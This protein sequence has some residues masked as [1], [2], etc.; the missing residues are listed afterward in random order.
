MLVKL[1]TLLLVSIAVTRGLIRS[2]ENKE[3]LEVSQLTVKVTKLLRRATEDSLS[4]T[5]T[6]DDESN[7]VV[8]VGS[9]EQVFVNVALHCGARHG[10]GEFVFMARRKLGDLALSCAPRLE[11]WVSIVRKINKEGTAHCVLRS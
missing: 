6:P 2:I 1:L 9:D 8:T 3:E 10:T 5:S 11:D 4:S 7:S